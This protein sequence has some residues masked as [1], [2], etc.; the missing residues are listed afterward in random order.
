MKL[1]SKATIRE[2][3]NNR[4]ER[5]RVLEYLKTTIYSKHGIMT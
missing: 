2:E 3:Q 5:E 1:T 4:H